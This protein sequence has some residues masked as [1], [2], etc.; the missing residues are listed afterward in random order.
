MA[1]GSTR[2]QRSTPVDVTQVERLIYLVRGQRV[3]L[4]QDLAALYGVTTKRFNEQIRR[5]RRRFPPDFMFKM[6]REEY[7]NLRSQFATSRNPIEIGTGENQ[8]LRSQFATLKTGRGKHRK[9]LP[10]LF[11]EH[12]AIMA[13]SVLN[14][15]KAVEMSIFVV[16][17]F[18]RLRE[19]LSTHHQLAAKLDELEG[20]LST[21]D[22]Q[23]VVLFEAIRQLMDE[24]VPEKRRIGFGVE[25]E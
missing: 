1:R 14:S 22:E 5:N 8:S 15:P 13:A 25:D 12:G 21:H 23:I 7:E 16:R 11:T 19:L 9:Y 24:P 3:V 17:A 6:T 10:N 2:K 18:V 4:D 20:K